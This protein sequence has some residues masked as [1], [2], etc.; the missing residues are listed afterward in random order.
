MSGMAAAIGARL[1]SWEGFL[2][3]LLLLI[4]GMNAL[5]SPSF[6]SVD[7]QINLFALSIEKVIVA[8]IMTF[9][10][11]N[12]E[13]DLSVASMMGLS[14]CALGWLIQQG[15][16]TP[17]A[18]VICLLVGILGGAF[19]GFWIT[20]VRLPSLVVTLAMLI[21]FRGFARVLIEDRSIKEFPAWFE[22]LGQQPLLGPFPLSLLVFF[23]LLVL[24]V[25]VLRYSGFGRQVQVIGINQ[26]VA[27]YSGIDVARVK[28]L[29]FT[30]SG[31][32]S[33][34]AGIL[35]AARLGTVR[36]DMGLGFELDIITIVLLGGVSIFGGAGS[37]Y[38]VLLSILIVLYLRNGMSLSN[39]TGHLQAGVIGI[40]LILSAMI[41][42]VRSFLARVAGSGRRR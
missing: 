22:A 15:V 10:I 36:G 30:T 28:L 33:A 16:P 5:T 29:L 23:G 39:I 11:L 17:A 20:A 8:L 1:R 7:N 27:R 38:G 26:E 4:V 13:I 21:G 40:I 24:A 35:F 25:I 14:A 18:L 42:N 34:L 3:A 41:P 12:G 6:L 19:N 2:A 32:L 37:I 31:L 9:V